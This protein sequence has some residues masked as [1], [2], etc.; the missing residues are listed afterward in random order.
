[1]LLGFF[2][3]HSLVDVFTRGT[4]LKEDKGRRTITFPISDSEQIFAKIYFEDSFKE[5]CRARILGSRGRESATRSQILVSKGAVT[6]RSLGFVDFREE[7]LRGSASFTAFLSEGETLFQVLADRPADHEYWLAA[8]FEQ[9]VQLHR[10]GLVH[11]DLKLNNIMVSDGKLYYV[12]TDGVKKLVGLSS[13]VKDVARLVVG[14]SEVDVVPDLI[15]K[16]LSVYCWRN[17]LSED[18]VLGKTKSLV[19]QIQKVHLHKYNR[20]SRTIW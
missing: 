20:F 6:P 14:L 2:Q 19:S 18:K 1:M 12:D 11:G 17:E 4:L 10:S 9:L 7:G 16:S 5:R 15:K 13:R 3:N 8:V